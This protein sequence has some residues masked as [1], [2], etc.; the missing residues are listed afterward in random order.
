[1]AK[2]VVDDG[3]PWTP[4]KDLAAIVEAAVVRCQ[5][6]ILNE[7]EAALKKHKPSMIGL[8]KNSPRN[9]A[10]A[11]LVRK[12]TTEG[13]NL[14]VTSSE[15]EVATKQKLPASIVEEALI[16]SEMFELNEISSLQLL[17]QGIFFK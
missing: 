6:G 3:N 8:L 17:L 1:M 14:P 2:N 5:P 4:L 16:I 12:A 7:L 10:D 9:S 11:A 13:I 15:S